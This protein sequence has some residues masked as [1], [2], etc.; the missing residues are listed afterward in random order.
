MIADQEGVLCMKANRAF[1]ENTRL[2]RHVPQK[3]PLNAET[4]VVSRLALR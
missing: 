1:R 3:D 2:A 4:G